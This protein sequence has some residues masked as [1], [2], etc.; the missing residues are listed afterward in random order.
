MSDMFLSELSKLGK[1]SHSFI[2]VV[3]STRFDNIK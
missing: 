3:V 2:S 1:N